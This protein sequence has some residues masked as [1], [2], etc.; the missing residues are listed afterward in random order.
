MEYR[1]AAEGVHKEIRRSTLKLGGTNPAGEEIS[2]TNYYMEVDG[3]PYIGICGEFHYSRYPEEDWERELV[4]MKMSGINIVATYIFWNH[5]EEEEGVFHWEGGL[6]LQR[7]IELCGRQGL[8]IILRVGPFCHGE[9]RNGGLPDWLFGRSFVVR[10]ND[11]EYLSYVRRLYGEIGRQAQGL[12]YREGGP[13]IGIQLENEYMASAAVWELTAKQGD[14]YTPGGDGGAEHMRLLKAYAVEAG[15]IA[16]LYTS[17]GWGNAPVL[18]DEVLPLYGGYAYTP[19]SVTAIHTEQEPTG[20]YVFANF[21]NDEAETAGFQP[22][23]PKSGY[24]FACCEMGGGMQAWYL[25]RFVVEPESVAAMTLV[26]LAGGCNFLG[27]Y[28]FHGGTN[29]AGRSGMYMN[30]SMT[31]KFTYD[32]QAPIGEFGQIRESNALVRPLH[33]FLR[34]FGPRL[35]PMAT[36]LPEN[37]GRIDPR[38]T[39][40]LRYALRVQ[41]REGFLFINNYQDHVEMKA[42][43]DVRFRVDLEGETIAFPRRGLL[44]EKNVSALL[45][46]NFD[47]DGV[48]LRYATAQPVTRTELQDG[49]GSVY[50]L[51]VP[52]GMT[53][54]FCFAAEAI[55]EVTV[56]AGVVERSADHVYVE[57]P[58][59]TSSWIGLRRSD[60][61]HLYVYAMDV[62][63]SGRLWEAE[64]GGRRRIFFSDVPFT[65]DGEKLS[66]YGAGGDKGVLREFTLGEKASWPHAKE[67]W[68]S[69]AGRFFT[70]HT[71]QVPQSETPVEIE[72]LRDDKFRIRWSEEAWNG[73]DDLMLTIDYEG[74]VGF[75]FAQGRLFHDHFW[76]GMPWEIGLRRFRGKLGSRE[77][78]LQVT[79][80]RSGTLSVSSD[81]AMAQNFIGES[82]ALIRSV[83][84]RPVYALELRR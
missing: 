64:L 46:L 75:A 76:N 80:R 28:M 70:T 77:I 57:V 72:R 10:S 49:G 34:H 60:G 12:L 48:R 63:E 62:Q 14:V 23:Y 74:D 82:V 4:K 42:H 78:I 38:N 31:P 32:F 39:D 59:G 51:A 19:W 69:E 45:P 83:T 11:E 13:V 52:R 21:H 47:L 5:H 24:P 84:V 9:V 67:G 58:A 79:P 65:A 54:E 2:F 43:R 68:S 40:D 26:K 71:V 3:A 25:S 56:E 30:E 55:A 53:G 36:V 15:L 73:V 37:A 44:V 1:I 17:T 41:G 18:E 66:L 8:Y 29:P 7:F 27:Y 35:A 22:P 16:P 61:T 50:F 6:N 33:Y 20:E 81:I